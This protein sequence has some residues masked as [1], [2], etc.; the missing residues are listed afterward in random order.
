M[1][2]I[3]VR[4]FSV[5]AILILASL[6]CLTLAD[7]KE[8]RLEDEFAINARSTETEIVIATA[9][10]E[11][12]ATSAAQATM[13]AICARLTPE[14][15]ANNGTHTYNETWSTNREDCIYINYEPVTRSQIITF[16]PANNR[17]YIEI[18]NSIEGYNGHER[19]AVNSYQFVH[20]IGNPTYTITFLPSGYVEEDDLSPNSDCIWTFT[21]IFNE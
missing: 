6:A 2:K 15:C 12:T 9:R 8:E 7:P 19:I 16:D 14:E 10:S 21:Y 4:L 1:P 20:P 11:A 3:R 18:F 5:G 17:M 13:D